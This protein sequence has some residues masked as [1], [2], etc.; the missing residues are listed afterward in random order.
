M[1]TYFKRLFK[2]NDI[3]EIRGRPDPRDDRV[4]GIRHWPVCRLSQTHHGTGRIL[5]RRED[6]RGDRPDRR[7][8]VLTCSQ[9]PRLLEARTRP[10]TVARKPSRAQ[11]FRR[12]KLGKMVTRL[13]PLYR[14]LANKT[15]Q[16]KS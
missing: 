9:A 16:I 5:G 12:R 4:R 13:G 7:A 15:V 14:H 8:P 2:T 1:R 6:A 3:Y 11:T 10:Q